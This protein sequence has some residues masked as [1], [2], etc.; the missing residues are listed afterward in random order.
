M[1][2][3]EIKDV[4][5]AVLFGIANQVEH[6]A[7]VDSFRLNRIPQI[8][9]DHVILGFCRALTLLANSPGDGSTVTSTVC[10]C[11]NCLA[12]RAAPWASICCST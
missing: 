11:Y 12:F 1:A 9:S 4:L 8:P 10:A 3:F 5:I 7:N 6:G 2:C